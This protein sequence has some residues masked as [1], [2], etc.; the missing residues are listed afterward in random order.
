MTVAVMHYVCT[1]L[2]KLNR[3]FKRLFA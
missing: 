3:D 2:N 1:L